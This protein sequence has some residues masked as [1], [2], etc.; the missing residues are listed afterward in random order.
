METLDH[1]FRGMRAIATLPSTPRNE[2]ADTPA[3]DQVS[4]ATKV[5]CNGAE[6]N[7]K[8]LFHEQQV[9]MARA[10]A[11]AHLGANARWDRRGLDVRCEGV[12]RPVWDALMRP[13][14]S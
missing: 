4:A 8:V 12:A 9:P 5:L 10:I 2:Q 14:P 7:A 3:I 11:N 1:P 6:R 13:L